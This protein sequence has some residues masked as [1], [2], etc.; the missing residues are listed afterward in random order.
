MFYGNVDGFEFLSPA[1]RLSRRRGKA[2][3]ARTNARTNARTGAPANAPAIAPAVA[4]T[5]A[6][7]IA[8]TG[9]PAIARTNAPAIAP[10][11]AR[12]G[13]HA[14]AR[15]VAAGAENPNN[16]RRG[17]SCTRP[18]IR[19]PFGVARRYAERRNGKSRRDD[20]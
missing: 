13:A 5:G 9:A 14:I 3:L 20:T 8:R 17:G 16:G 15:T 2:R 18:R 1:I 19:P 6:T 12:T 4:R 10:A 11:I 7:A